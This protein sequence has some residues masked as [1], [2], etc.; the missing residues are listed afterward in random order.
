[1]PNDIKIEDS[2]SI[3]NPS[4]TLGGTPA[5]ID[6]I[7]IEELEVYPNPSQGLFN[8]QF[9][10]AEINDIELIIRNFSG[11]VVYAEKMNSFIGQFSHQIN[12]S[13]FPKSVYFLEISNGTSK[14]NR[15]LVLQ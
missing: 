2:G 8:I 7:K 13:L 9:T 3:P 1:M 12:L 11:S 6:D 10:C 14:L 5:S 15:K 4:A